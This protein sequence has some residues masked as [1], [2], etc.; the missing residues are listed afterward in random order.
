MMP[1]TTVLDTTM[2]KLT[3]RD[4]HRLDAYIARP[5]AM[6][7]GGVV[8]VQ[9][10]YGLNPYLRTVCEFYAAHGYEV[11]AP[12]LYDRHQ[13][14][15]IFDYSKED[16]DR[17]QKVYKNWDFD[18]ALDDMDA[19]RDVVATTGRIGVVGFCWGGTL[20]WLAACR[21]SYACAVAYYGS[22]MPSYAEEKP[23]CPA[24]AHIG[25]RDTTLPP[26]RIDLFRAARPE[27]PVYLYS[28]AQHGFDNRD[29]HPRYHEQACQAARERTLAFF[30]D[31][32]R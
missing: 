21:R 24:I 6:P 1:D 15:L 9:E 16:H 28:G 30:A 12:A 14:G 8:V 17:A 32:I 26:A 2:I 23:R 10:M 22:M 27:V 7:R 4:G 31:H 20:A 11:I 25:D 18:L 19:A 13:P 29:R 5:S 3:A